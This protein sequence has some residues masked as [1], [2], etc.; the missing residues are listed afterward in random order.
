MNMP[1]TTVAFH[2]AAASATLLPLQP[3]ADQHVTARDNDLTVPELNALVAAL[4]FGVAPTQ[5]QIRSPSLRAMILEDI[6]KTIVTEVC[7]GAVDA[8]VDRREDP[9]ICE[10]AEK[11]NVYTIHTTDGWALLWLA[12]G[13]V[14]PVHGDIRTL[15]ATTGHTT[16][17]DVWTNVALTF[18]QTLPAGRYQVVGMRAHG[19]ALLA[20]RLVFIG[21]GWRPGVPAGADIN[22]VEVPQFRKGRFGAF[23][24]FEFDAP[25]TVDLLG[26]GVTSVEEIYLDLIQVRA[27]RG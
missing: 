9:L 3:I 20:A 8:L 22:A 15:R 13:P 16:V 12:D 17:Q 26:T 7:A 27:G 19:T 25:P 2:K 11:L 14:A 23:G 5:A 4:V 24:E 6:G 10:I 21:Y 18:D 1:F